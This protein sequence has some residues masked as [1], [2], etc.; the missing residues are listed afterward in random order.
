MLANKLSQLLSS[1][2][3]VLAP[4]KTCPMEV[5]LLRLLTLG[6]FL[7]ALAQLDAAGAQTSPPLCQQG[8][9]PVRSGSGW[10]CSKSEASNTDSAKT[11]SKPD[12]HGHGGGTGGFG[13]MPH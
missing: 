12:R 10:V 3:L 7:C 1:N 5:D 13:G 4:Y 2:E 9:W 8:T 11:D 6:L